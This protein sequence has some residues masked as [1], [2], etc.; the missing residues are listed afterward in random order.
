MALYGLDGR[1]SSESG[2]RVVYRPSMCAVGIAVVMI[3]MRTGIIGPRVGVSIK[4]V[5]RMAL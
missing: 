2:G 1:S 3:G 5:R 4:A